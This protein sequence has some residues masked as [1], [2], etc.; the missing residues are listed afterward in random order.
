[1]IKN[2][3]LK[4]ALLLTIA[5]PAGAF[6]IAEIIDSTK[7]GTR[8]SFE[9]D[10]DKSDSSLSY[11]Q[12]YFGTFI[13]Q[14]IK[15]ADDWTFFNYF[16]AERTQINLKGSHFYGSASDDLESDLYNIS[17]PLAVIKNSATS[18]WTY[19]FWVNPTIASDFSHLDGDDFFLDLGAGV[20]YRYSDDLLIGLGVYAS[21]VTKDAGIIGGPGFIWTPCDQ[22]LISFYGPR[23]LA[24]YHLSERS[25]IGFEIASRGGKWNLDAD[26]QSRKAYLQNWQSGLY[27]RQ[28]VYKKLWVQIGAGYSFAQKLELTD[29]EGDRFLDNND[30][31]ADGS[32]YVYLSFDVAKW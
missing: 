5:T 10:F 30:G 15:F 11:N 3:L 2:T 24:R 4:A 25:Q 12:T 27:L 1:M 17:L 23:F 32:P 29:R 9:A 20:G 6:E 14:P 28:N 13:N 8:F 26:D 21:D 31:D 22:W 16:S 18:K 19:G 7:I